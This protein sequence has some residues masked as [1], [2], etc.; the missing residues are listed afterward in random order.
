MRRLHVRDVVQVRRVREHRRLRPAM[1]LRDEHAGYAFRPTDI[2]V[3]PS[4]NRF[5]AP[6]G[7][8]AAGGGRE[9]FP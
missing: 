8:E 3:T 6:T 1:H 4:F 7:L 9:R 2:D 5:L